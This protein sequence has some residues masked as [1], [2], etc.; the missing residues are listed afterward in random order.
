MDV[1]DLAVPRAGPAA[2]NN[3]WVARLLDE[4]HD[5]REAVGRPR[6]PR[7]A[8]V[9][10]P[11]SRPP[12]RG[13]GA[14]SR[15][16]RARGRPPG[17]RPGARAS[18][19]A[20]VVGRQVRLERPEAWS[21]LG[22]ARRSGSARFGAYAKAPGGRAG[23]DGWA[24]LGRP[25]PAMTV[26]PTLGPRPML[27]SGRSRCSPAGRRGRRGRTP[28][29]RST[30]GAC[31]PLHGGRATAVRLI[32][33]ALVL[34][35]C[36]RDG[37]ADRHEPPRRPPVPRPLRPPTQGGLRAGQLSGRRRRPVRPERR[38]RTRPMR[39]TGGELKRIRATAART[40]VFELCR[41]DVA[42]LAKIA[43]PAIRDQTTAGW[44]S[45]HITPGAS[46]QQAI[47]SEVNGTGPYELERWGPRHRGQ[48]GP[49]TTV[50]PVPVPPT[51]A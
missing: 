34:A 19:R 10:E 36:K 17:P 24:A 5:R 47:V 7:Q 29:S 33:V 41:P 2:M 4:R 25:S 32:V 18:S 14:G 40:V 6:E 11:A 8:R 42:F 30:R 23:D 20:C 46:G 16:T 48:P 28:R 39:P 35:A 44:I 13:P 22:R 37:P 43:S 12:R 45:H 51:S 15:S 9:V 27:G 3:R 1:P 31:Q 21:D 50:T 26:P 49:K 38:H